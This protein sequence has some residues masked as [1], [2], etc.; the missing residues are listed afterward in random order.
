MVSS[1]KTTC[2]HSSA[3]LFH[4]VSIFEMLPAPHFHICLSKDN[5]QLMWSNLHRSLY[6][7]VFPPTQLRHTGGTF[8][9]TICHCHH[10]SLKTH[11]GRKAAVIHRQVS[12]AWTASW[13]DVTPEQ[14]WWWNG[15]GIPPPTTIGAFRLGLP[16]THWDLFSEAAQRH[17]SLCYLEKNQERSHPA[18]VWNTRLT[19]LPQ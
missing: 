6:S 10:I 19:W 5:E 2:F 1:L 16:L 7:S 9:V 18:T 14:L 12:I 11:F 4:I 8:L 13:G 15:D 3:G 17:Y